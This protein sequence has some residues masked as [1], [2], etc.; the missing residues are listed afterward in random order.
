MPLYEFQCLKCGYRFELK[1]ELRQGFGEPTICPVVCP[2][3]GGEVERKVSNFSFI[4][5]GAKKSKVNPNARQV[6]G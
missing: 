5:A 1:Q 6:R 3:C 4:F 2:E